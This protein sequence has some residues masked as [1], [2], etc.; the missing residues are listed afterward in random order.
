MGGSALKNC[1]LRRVPRPEY[2]VVEGRVLALV[3]QFFAKVDVPRYLDSKPD[4][5]DVDCVCLART[6]WE[7]AVPEIAEAFSSREVVWTSKTTVSLERD[8]FQIDLIVVE[9]E[10]G[11]DCMLNYLSYGDAGAIMGAI[12]KQFGLSF[13]MD[14]LSCP[15][16]DTDEPLRTLGRVHLSKDFALILAYLGYDHARFFEGNLGL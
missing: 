12:A 4:F 15:V 13:G 14:G 8:S 10:D 1:V 11:Y 9:E 2:L 5:G 7:A 16:F 6:G 3:R